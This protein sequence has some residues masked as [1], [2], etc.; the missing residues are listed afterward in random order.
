MGL[1]LANKQRGNKHKHGKKTKPKTLHKTGD[2]LGIFLSAPSDM[3][4]CGSIINILCTVRASMQR[5]IFSMKIAGHMLHKCVCASVW[6]YGGLLLFV[7]L[8]V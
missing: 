4:P 2:N 1:V 7:W 5:E 6:K 8:D 3:D